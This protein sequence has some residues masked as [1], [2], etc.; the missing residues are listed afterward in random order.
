MID[1]H[2]ALSISGQAKSAGTSRGSVYYLPKPVSALRAGFGCHGASKT[3]G[4]MDGRRLRIAVL[5][6]RKKEGNMS[7]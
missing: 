5:R 1:G 2:H 3:E 4:P 7:L 6:N